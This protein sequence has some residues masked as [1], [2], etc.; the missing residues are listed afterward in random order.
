MDTETKATATA[1]A[2]ANTAISFRSLTDSEIAA[3]V[4]ANRPIMAGK[5]PGQIRTALRASDSTLGGKSLTK[6]VDAISAAYGNANREQALTEAG[7]AVA[8][9]WLAGHHYTKTQGKLVCEFVRPKATADKVAKVFQAAKALVASNDADKT[10][11]LDLM[12]TL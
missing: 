8:S 5:L 3:L 10:R 4:L 2:T 11:L 7:K 9:G 6:V 1:T 12:A